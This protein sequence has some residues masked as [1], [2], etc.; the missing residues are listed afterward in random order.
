MVLM[1]APVYV[2]ALRSSTDE[3]LRTLHAADRVSSPF[4]ARPE[5]APLAP[6]ARCPLDRPHSA[7]SEVGGQRGAHRRHEPV[8][9]SRVEAR[10]PER[11]EDPQDAV[12]P[13]DARLEPA[14][15]PVAVQDREDVVA[16]AALRGR[17]V[18]LPDI[19]EPEEPAQQLAVPGERV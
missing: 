15:E 17:D 19:V 14:D 3:L 4:R 7:E 1:P 6:E 5:E 16:P 18:D 8:G 10:L 13:L 12:G 2:L 9:P 11:A